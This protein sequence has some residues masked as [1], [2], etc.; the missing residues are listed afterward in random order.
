MTTEGPPLTKPL[1]MQVTE[2]AETELFGGRTG[3]MLQGQ[4]GAPGH[5]GD[6]SWAN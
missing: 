3:K 2:G 5:V 1:C 4:T 6:L